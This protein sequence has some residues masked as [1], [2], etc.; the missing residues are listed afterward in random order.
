MDGY[1]PSTPNDGLEPYS[2][3]SAT[4]ANVKIRISAVDHIFYAIGMLLFLLLRHVLLLLQQEL[5][6][7]LLKALLV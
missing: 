2:F 3:F 5:H 7:E 6:L 4:G 1:Y